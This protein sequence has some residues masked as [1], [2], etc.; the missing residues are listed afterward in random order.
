M[1]GYWLEDIKG[2]RLLHSDGTWWMNERSSVWRA[3]GGTRKSDAPRFRSGDK[4]PKADVDRSGGRNV[5]I[6]GRIWLTVAAATTSLTCTC[7]TTSNSLP[8]PPPSRRVDLEG[9]IV[10]GG[11]A[12][13]DCEVSRR[14]LKQ[15]EC[16]AK[17]C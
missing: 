3:T 15:L 4:L 5:A 9:F 16:G 1:L 17:I 11:E 10:V 7:S 14:V 13:K 12:N 6:E 2:E 8:F